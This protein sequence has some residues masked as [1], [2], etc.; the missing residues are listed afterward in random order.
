MIMDESG[1][2]K[3]ENFVKMRDFVN[4]LLDNLNVGQNRTHVGVL[5]FSDS[6]TLQFHMNKFMTR[7]EIQVRSGPLFIAKHE[8]DIN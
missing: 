8:C 2:V 6:T 3:D 7:K 4:R 5:K 1:S